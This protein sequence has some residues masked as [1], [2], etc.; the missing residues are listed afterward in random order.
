MYDAAVNVLLEI[1]PLWDAMRPLLLSLRELRVPGVAPDM[2]YWTDSWKT[3]VVP[4][5][6]S[7][8]PQ[9][10]VSGFHALASREQEHDHELSELRSRFAKYCLERLKARDKGGP[11]LEPS[12]DWRWAYIRAA[13]ELR[14]NPEGNGHRILHQV[15]ANDPDL[16]VRQEA[17][18]AY[19][20][21][22]HGPTL[23]AGMS[24]RRTVTNA[25]V[26]LFQ[27]HFLSVKQPGVEMDLPGVLR[28]REE[29]ARRT[30]EP[31]WEK[32]EASPS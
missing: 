32:K 8:V 31:E 7:W 13:R 11:P 27:A 17:K 23:P 3:Q 29:I 2:R 16:G 30:T 15:A 14:V 24:P 26:W 25:I 18:V 12:D 22:R 1:G 10:L 6:W 21:L 28:T 9:E 20:D 4:E 19:D 5:P